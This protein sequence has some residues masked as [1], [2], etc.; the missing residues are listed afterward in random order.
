MRFNKLFL[1][2]IL[3]SIICSSLIS[4]VGI[5]QFFSNKIIPFEPGAETEL[6][7][8]VFDSSNIQ[9]SLEGDL[10]PYASLIDTNPNGGP[11]TIIIKL[12]FP[13][14]LPP[15]DHTL[16]L[17]ATEYTGQE[18]SVGGLASVR[19]G[20]KAFALYP[21]KHPTL[22]GIITQDMNINESIEIGLSITNQGE[23][24]IDS[25]Y[26]EMKVYNQEDI[27]IASI[28]T[29]SASI[30]SYQGV[31]VTQTLNGSIYNLTPGK[32]RVNG[33]LI[34]DGITHP[35]TAEG[36]FRVGTMDINIVDSTKDVIINATNKYKIVIESDWAGTINDVYARI[37]M[38][39]G[40]SLKTPNV[41]LV[42]AG[43]GRKGA[44]ELETYWETEGLATGTYDIDINIYYN[45]QIVT[46]KARVNVING[47][48]PIIDKPQES[49]STVLII[50]I[51]AVVLLIIIALYLTV[52][53]KKDSSSSNSTK[54]VSDGEIKP[55]SL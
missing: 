44:A 19:A 17:V 38:P 34:Y 15:G 33:T 42:S 25:A 10:M 28:T 37:T 46:K 11:R 20:I 49:N 3:S 53:R 4:S 47:I 23:D 26:G 30:A 7:L 35:T 32:Y 13:D 16:Y 12:K 22:Q 54:T 24:T 1:L 21:A 14:Y 8:S 6:K 9:V 43:G 29:D 52:F 48:A 41:D 51:S 18:Q 2:L 5:G 31:S 50:I 45:G 40:K 39:N 36:T 55:P 27:L